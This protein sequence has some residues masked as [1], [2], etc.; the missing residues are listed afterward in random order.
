MSGGAPAPD[1]IPQI[2]L[3]RDWLERERGL[4]FADYAALWTWSTTDLEGFWRSVWDYHQLSSPTPFT[5][6]LRD[7]ALPAAT[8]FDGASVNYAR[9]VFRHVDQAEALGLPAII[10]EDERGR[11][12][13][14]G[15]AELR[16]RS[17]SLALALRDSGV[18]R[19][20]RVAAY[21]PNI[22][23]AAIAL[24]ACASLGAIWTICSPDMGTRAGRHTPRTTAR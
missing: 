13:E 3:Y 6:V 4:A 22:P 11:V 20:D 21:L 19:G 2:R 16:R 23:E 10:A 8:W 15:W 14:L 24:L 9:Q 18:V 17:A 7:E 12:T 1:P 5:S